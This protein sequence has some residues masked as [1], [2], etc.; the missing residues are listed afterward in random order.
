M[1]FWTWKNWKKT[2][3]I[4]LTSRWKS[5][6]VNSCSFWNPAS[7]NW[8]RHRKASTRVAPPAADNPIAQPGAIFCLRQRQQADA[9][10][11]AETDHR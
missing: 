4:S 7:A 8:N 3:S 2:A 11:Q 9:E 5:S 6:A 10:A 1:K